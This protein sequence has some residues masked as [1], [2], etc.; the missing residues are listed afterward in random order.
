MLAPYI[1]AYTRTLALSENETAHWRELFGLIMDQS[2][3]FHLYVA[4]LNDRPVATAMTVLGDGVAGLYHLGTVADVRGRGIGTAVTAVPLHD[5][6]TLG[7]RIGALQTTS[8][9]YSV[10]HRI[11]FRE[12]CTLGLYHL[13]A[14]TP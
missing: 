8:M 2:G 7:C 14:G 9:G 11:G 6:R 10:Y 12:Y 13:P 1:D 3:P 4:L 5:A